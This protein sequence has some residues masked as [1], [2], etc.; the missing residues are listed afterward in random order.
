MK[1]VIGP[2]YVTNMTHFQAGGLNSSTNYTFYIRTYSIAASER[3]EKITCETGR[4]S[5][6]HRVVV[7]KPY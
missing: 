4:N 6:F 3:S 2:D 7:L 1:E 5:N